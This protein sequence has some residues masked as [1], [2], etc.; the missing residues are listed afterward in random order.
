MTAK[1]HAS[2]ESRKLKK[3]KAAAAFSY[4]VSAPLPYG[5]LPSRQSATPHVLGAAQC[6]A[7]L[8]SAAHCCAVAGCLPPFAYV[9]GAARR[10][11]RRGCMHA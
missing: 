6:C 10:K 8:R 7:V 5:C 9:R 2:S 11:T 3:R 4:G 1:M